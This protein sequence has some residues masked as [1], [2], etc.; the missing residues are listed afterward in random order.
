MLILSFSEIINDARVLKQVNLFK[1]GWAVTTCGFGPAPEGVAE[2]LRVPDD[3]IWLNLD[4]RLITLKQ[5]RR[6]LRGRK[7]DFQV[8]LA[9]EP[10]AVPVALGLSPGWG[11]HADLHE[12]TPSL[13]EQNPAW[14]R[15][16]KPYFEWL[17][18]KYVRRAD[19]WSSPSDGVGAKYLK[20]FGFEPTTVAN[21][22]PHEPLSPS[23]VGD[24][25]RFVH[26][27]GAQR[28]RRLDVMIQAFMD[29][30]VEGSFDLFLTGVDPQVRDDSI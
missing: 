24:A 15:R 10:E 8:V 21:A 25:I 16:I 11:V 22:A 29:S 18:G 7:H 28:N 19:S 5:Y 17:V 3:E 4:G 2:H 30:K 20:E 9:N 26:H 12:Y 14:N 6:L 13:Y 27:G 23:P 1:D